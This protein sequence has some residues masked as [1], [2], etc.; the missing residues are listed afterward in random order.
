ML[1]SLNAQMSVDQR[2]VTL[3]QDRDA[4]AKA[5]DRGGY[6]FD[7]VVVLSRVARVGDEFIQ[8]QC[9]GFHK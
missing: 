5:F 1:C 9:Y 4:E 3:C 8:W 2:A 7:G 6:G